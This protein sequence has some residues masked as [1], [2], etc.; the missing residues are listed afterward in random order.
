M[1]TADCSAVDAAVFEIDATQKNG[2]KKLNTIFPLRFQN[3]CGNG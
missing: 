1:G 3:R 2:L